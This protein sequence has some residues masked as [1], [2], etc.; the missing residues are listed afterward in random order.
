MTIPTDTTTP[1]VAAELAK[2][3][4]DFAAELRAR[5]NLPAPPPRTFGELADKAESIE[6]DLAALTAPVAAAPLP[7][8]STGWMQLE[9]ELA[10]S[11]APRPPPPRPRRWPLAV[12]LAMV[13][14]LVALAVARHLLGAP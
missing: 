4:A 8:L 13:V 12:V 6:A 2:D 10:A 1:N 5:C 3:A 14:V 9:A 7:K 11:A